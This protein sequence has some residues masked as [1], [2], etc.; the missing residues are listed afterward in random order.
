M[1]TFSQQPDYSTT[2]QIDSITL[3]S[4]DVIDFTSINMSSGLSTSYSS[5]TITITGLTSSPVYSVGAGGYGGPG[6]SGTITIGGGGSSGFST[7]TTTSGTISISPIDISSIESL[8]Q[9]EWQNR[10]PDWNRIQKMCEEYPGLKIAFEKF[11]TTYYLVKDDYDN[12]NSK[13]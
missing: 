8:I 9:T 4:T 1:S 3:G 6:S 13:K 10:F 12:P 5:D 7:L 2:S 11:K